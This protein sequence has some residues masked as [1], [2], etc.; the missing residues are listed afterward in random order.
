[1]PACNQ[2][3]RYCVYRQAGEQGRICIVGWAFVYVWQDDYLCSVRGISGIK[4][5]VD[6]DCGKFSS[7]VHEYSSWTCAHYHWD[8][9]TRYH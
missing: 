9:F 3:S 6:T 8:Y 7:I 2:Y 5:A 1:M 4:R